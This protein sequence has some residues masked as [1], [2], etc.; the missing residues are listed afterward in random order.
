M[1]KGTVDRARLKAIR[2]ISES[3]SGMGI[4]CD[5][6]MANRVLN[7]LWAAYQ[8]GLKADPGLEQAVLNGQL[9][10]SVVKPV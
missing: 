9:R 5:L 8:R 7:N 1:K 10:L 4:P 3:L 2:D 6:F